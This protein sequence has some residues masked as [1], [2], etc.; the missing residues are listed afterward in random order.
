MHHQQA[1]LLLSDSSHVRVLAS[2]ENWQQNRTCH[3]HEG[4]KIDPSLEIA[5][6]VRQL[7][8]EEILSPR[9]PMD[10]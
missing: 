9:L 4:V 10:R 2:A 7:A 6:R 3:H 5:K 1:F 8:Q